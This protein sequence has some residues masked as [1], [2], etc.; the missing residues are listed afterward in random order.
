VPFSQWPNVP[1]TGKK[2]EWVVP[3][4]FHTMI[5]DPSPASA[6]DR[7]IV[8]KEYLPWVA[9]GSIGIWQYDI[10]KKVVA[11][12]GNPK[13]HIVKVNFDHVINT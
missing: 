7:F 8:D 12:R 11:L 4:E 3:H 2:F 6:F 13:P 5:R 10:G 1:L 9:P